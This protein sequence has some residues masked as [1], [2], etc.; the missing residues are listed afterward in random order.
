LPRSTTAARS[1]APGRKEASVPV[2][3]PAPAQGL[4]PLLAQLADGASAGFLLL[5]GLGAVWSKRPEGAPPAGNQPGDAETWHRVLDVPLTGR[6]QALLQQIAVSSRE[7]QADVHLLPFESLRPAAQAV[8]DQ[9]QRLIPEIEHNLHLAEWLEQRVVD[10]E[11][12]A[13]GAPDPAPRSRPRPQQSLMGIQVDPPAEEAA[14]AAPPLAPVS[15]DPAVQARLADIR[16]RIAAMDAEAERVAQ[17]LLECEVNLLATISEQDERRLGELFAE[18]ADV[19]GMHFEA[20]RE[21]NQL[22]RGAEPPR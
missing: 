6:R 11:R 19:F 21:V 18:F 16:A 1:P 14:G 20:A 22:M 2:P 7:I 4:G 17:L 10:L 9:Q 3:V 13:A 12:R 8:V 15:L 5:V